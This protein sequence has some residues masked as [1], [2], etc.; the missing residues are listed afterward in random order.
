M[1]VFV[2]SIGLGLPLTGCLVLLK[3]LK[4]EKGV[5][6]VLWPGLLLLLFDA[7]GLNIFVMVHWL[8]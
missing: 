8:E 4:S 6:L 7:A 3:A 1:Q 5:V 2:M